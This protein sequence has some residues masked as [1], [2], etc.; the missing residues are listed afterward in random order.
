MGNAVANNMDKESITSRLVLAGGK[1]GEEK[2]RRVIRW[3]RVGTW[4]WW[5]RST[6][7]GTT[8]VGVVG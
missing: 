7:F 5:S 4:K 6:G 2:A 8:G 1:F 3:G